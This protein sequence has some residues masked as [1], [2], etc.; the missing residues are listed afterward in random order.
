[1]HAN[2]AAWTYASAIWISWLRRQESARV[3]GRKRR[4]NTRRGS[5][6]PGRVIGKTPQTAGEECAPSPLAPVALIERRLMAQNAPGRPFG[7]DRPL[8]NVGSVE[9]DP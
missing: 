8:V 7:A 9:E 4:E 6:L 2:P 3:S 1:M 5:G